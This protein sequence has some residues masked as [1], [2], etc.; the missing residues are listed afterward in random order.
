MRE[1]R[2]Q[3]VRFTWGNAAPSLRIVREVSGRRYRTRTDDPHR[4]KVT[5]RM[6]SYCFG[7]SNFHERKGFG[8]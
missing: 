8:C 3:P 1:K 7:I 4:V 6:P 5:P 2:R